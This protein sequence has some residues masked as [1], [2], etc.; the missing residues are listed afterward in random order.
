[1]SIRTGSRGAPVTAAQTRLNELGSHI[2]VDGRY[3]RETATAVREFQ[4]S[5]HLQVDGVVGRETARAM[6]LT[7]G[8]DAPAAP[9]GR[10]SRSHA[11]PAATPPATTIDPRRG[12]LITP[13]EH[14]E[15]TPIEQT[16]LAANRM[17]ARL[18]GYTQRG[19]P[20]PPEELTRAHRLSELMAIPLPLTADPTGEVNDFAVARGGLQ[21]RL[22]AIDGH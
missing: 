19:E 21:D 10:S 1:M 4:R 14:R 16:T 11:A 3:G 22:R 9:S 6:G 20:V 7:D 12:A 8:F 17:N 13:A 2:R 15:L 5:H 18:D